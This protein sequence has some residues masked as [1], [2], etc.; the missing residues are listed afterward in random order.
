MRKAP[1]SVFDD[2]GQRLD[3]DSLIG[4]GGEAS[5][6][7]V[8]SNANVLVKIYHQ[9]MSAEKVAKVRLMATMR[10][11]ML[12]KLTAWPLS[13]AVSGPGLSPIGLVMPNFPNRKDI[14]LLYSPKSRRAEFVRA[15]WRFLVRA[16][17]NTARS[18]AIVHD[19]GSVI[20]D[21]NHGSMLVGQDAT[22]RLV[23]C[24]SFQISNGKQLYECKVGVETFTPPELQG[25]S[26]AGIVRTKNHDAFGLA[27]AI[28]HLLFMGRHPFAGRYLGAGDMPIAKAIEEVRFPY[29]RSA[30]DVKMLR[31][32]GTPDLAAAGPGIAELFERA[33]SSSTRTGG[34]PDA[35]EW[36]KGLSELESNVAQCALNTAHWHYKAISCPW[37]KMEAATGVPLFPVIVQGASSSVS[38]DE[39]WRQLSAVP[40]PG[41]APR[42]VSFDIPDYVPS[43][44]SKGPGQ[45]ARSIAALVGVGIIIVG[46]AINAKAVTALVVL[47]G[48]V[49][50]FAGASLFETG[51]DHSDLIRRYVSAR[52]D[53]KRALAEWNSRAGNE[54]FNKQLLALQGLR[55]KHSD[56]GQKRLSRLAGLR[57]KQRD[58]QVSRYLDQFKIEFARIDGIG[59]GRKQ[60]LASYGIETAAD[61][62]SVRIAAVPGFGP[63][64]ALKLQAWRRVQE[65]GFRY[66]GTQPIHPGDIASVESEIRQEENSLAAALRTGIAELMRIQGMVVASRL[67]LRS[68]VERLEKNFASAQTELRD[69]MRS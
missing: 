59:A 56:L 10:N 22:V 14:H 45:G 38:F 8:R 28:F 16:A 37:C 41:P 4:E 44:G 65:S 54:A 55:A 25:R 11:E 20:G 64:L 32:P 6:Y 33:F 53:L 68:G 60:T 42:I 5:V 17:A 24:D 3:I 61:I 67:H 15:D 7:R 30:Q 66:D 50:I 62:T 9:P 63:K 2:S 31:P 46:F 1:T 19:T 21:V 58:S 51:I 26:F 49:M 18:F 47:A 34:R 23:D 35:R 43:I 57:A 27:V 36:I 48:L 52:D 12:A 39:L 13:L 29:G 69:V 40:N